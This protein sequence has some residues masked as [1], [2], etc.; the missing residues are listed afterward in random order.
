MA[1]EALSVF[2]SRFFKSLL[3]CTSANFRSWIKYRINLREL[4]HQD[5]TGHAASAFIEPAQKIHERQ[6]FCSTKHPM[7]RNKASG[8]KYRRVFEFQRCRIALVNADG[9]ANDR[10]GT[11]TASTASQQK[12]R[13][14]RSA[15]RELGKQHAI[16]IL[17][18]HG[19]AYIVSVFNHLAD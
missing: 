16:G 14:R 10:G 13:H 6:A 7:A 8:L 19:S 3:H 18:I 5:A 12:H 2:L 9:G 15:S 4:S 1:P 11:R 17:R